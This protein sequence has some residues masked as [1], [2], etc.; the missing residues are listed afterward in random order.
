MKYEKR[1][2]ISLSV[3]GI[4]AIFLSVLYNIFETVF[5]IKI[6][7]S[8]LML[9]SFI[10]FFKSVK[11][12][13][14]YK[15]EISKDTFFKFINFLVV[16]GSFFLFLFTI[17]F[18]FAFQNTF[19]LVL[20][21]FLLFCMLT[22]WSFGYSVCR[23]VLKEK[24]NKAALNIYLFTVFKSVLSALATWI[25]IIYFFPLNCFDSILSAENLFRL[26]SKLL[27]DILTLF[28]P[29]FDMYNFTA[30]EIE[31]YEQKEEEKK[32]EKI[33]KKRKITDYIK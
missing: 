15:Y 17:I 9:I 14:F 12:F 23:K 19:N 10:I 16:V 21:Y 20:P 18:V 8:I 3:S 33:V 11:N 31:K 28:V 22:F 5:C 27:V 26:F 24:V 4:I 13:F 30:S 1:N 32:E 7:L 6:L 29:F 25:V 2:I